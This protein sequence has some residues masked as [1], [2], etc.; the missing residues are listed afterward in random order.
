MPMIRAHCHDMTNDDVVI[1]GLVFGRDRV[2]KPHE[3]AGDHRIPTVRHPPGDPCPS[4]HYLASELVG[5]RL[6]RTCENV[7]REF[8]CSRICGYVDEF[9]ITLNEIN[10]GAMETL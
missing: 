7:D 1:A 9:A 4:V 6:L 10:G 3:C 2:I 5:Q 8:P